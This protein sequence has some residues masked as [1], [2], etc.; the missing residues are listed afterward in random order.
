[1][2]VYPPSG[3]GSIAGLT[4]APQARQEHSTSLTN[5]GLTLFKRLFFNDSAKALATALTGCAAR[6]QY[7]WRLYVH[8]A[9]ILPWQLLYPPT[10][11]TVELGK[12]PFWGLVFNI[13]TIYFEADDL[14]EMPAFS[15]RPA[16]PII[17]T[18][19][20][21]DSLLLVNYAPW[22]ASINSSQQL[23]AVIQTTLGS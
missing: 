23:Q 15:A 21:T 14:S 19:G 12:E 10:R 7:P 3:T 22:L 13:S 2:L 20:P 16:D 5:V 9:A 18:A 17:L 6:S 4:V 1:Q 11:D 8:S